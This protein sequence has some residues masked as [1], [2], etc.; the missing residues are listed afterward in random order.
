MT[1]TVQV[2]AVANASGT[3][4]FGTEPVTAVTAAG[5]TYATA[6][7]GSASLAAGFNLVTGCNGSSAVAVALPSAPAT[8]MVVEVKNASD[9]ALS[10]FPDGAAAINAIG[11]HAALSLPAY[12]ACK[13]VATSATQ[14]Y[15]IPLVPS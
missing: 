2:E 9:N 12:T 6:V 7:S 14:W 10:V 5:T 15:S 11:S 8:N 3:I 13:F 1:V 4:G